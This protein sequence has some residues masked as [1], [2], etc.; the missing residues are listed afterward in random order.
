MW[1]ECAA[2]R[3]TG[4]DCNRAHVP[5]IGA[6]AIRVMQANIDPEIDLVILRVPPAGI[7]D[8]I[9]I[10]RGVDG[11][12]RDA[13]VHTIVT[14]VIDPIAEA[15]RPVSARARVAHAGLWRRRASRRGRWTILARD[16]AGVCKDDI[17]VG[18]VWCGVVEDGFL[19]GT[20]GI[21]RIEKWRDRPLERERRF[22]RGAAHTEEETTKEEDR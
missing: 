10:R 11:T 18:V 17:V 22:R 21:R 1:D 5:V 19:R 20:A 9:R 6:V 4:L 14:I 13:V 3:G 16:I 8:L 7:D 2:R 15:V 12:I